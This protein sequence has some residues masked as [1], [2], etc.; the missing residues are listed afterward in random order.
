[1]V[2]AGYGGSGEDGQAGMMRGQDLRRKEERERERERESQRGRV[3]QVAAVVVVVVVALTCV[4]VQSGSLKRE[5][6]TSVSRYSVCTGV[7][8][9]NTAAVPENSKLYSSSR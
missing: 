4:C 9:S 8:L 7:P 1:V 3:L 5:G 6:D 2:E